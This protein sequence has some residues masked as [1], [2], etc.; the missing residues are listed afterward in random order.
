M[1][2]LLTLDRMQTVLFLSDVVLMDANLISMERG[3]ED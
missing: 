3:N 2:N 1:A